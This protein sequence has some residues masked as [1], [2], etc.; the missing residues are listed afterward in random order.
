VP[1]L[2]DFDLVDCVAPDGVSVGKEAVRLM[3]PEVDQPAE[4][5]GV[6]L[7]VPVKDFVTD[8]TR[9]KLRVAV[10]VS[11]PGLCETFSVLVLGVQRLCEILAVT[12][13]VALKVAVG[14]TDLVMV[15]EEERVLVKDPGEGEAV[16]ECVPVSVMLGSRDHVGDVVRTSETER[17]GVPLH[18][19]VVLDKVID[20]VLVCVL[21]RAAVAVGEGV[22]VGDKVLVTLNGCVV[23]CVGT[24]G[25]VVCVGVKVALG[26]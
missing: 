17:V 2:S 7:C 19:A 9:L 11:D 18:V 15:T 25:V 26:L 23:L 22:G 20:C 5:D 10:G 6:T 8:L 12:L 4:A 3:V 13:G 16:S 24:G 21:V 14:T 1:V